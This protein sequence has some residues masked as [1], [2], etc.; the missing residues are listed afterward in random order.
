M[1]RFDFQISQIC[2]TFG[3]MNRDSTFHPLCV[4]AGTDDMRLN[5]PFDYEPHTLVL[6]AAERVRERILMLNIEQ[7]REFHSGK[8]LGVL[9]VR[10]GCEVGFLAA[11]SGSVLGV[12]T[13]EWFVPPIYDLNSE[14]GYFRDCEGEISTIN[15]EIERIEN[16][17]EYHKLSEDCK[18]AESTLEEA[19]TQARAQY[20]A[21]KAQ[22]KVL[23]ESGEREA[24]ERAERES[25]HQKG[26]IRRLETHLRGE[27]ERSAAALELT[28]SELS[29]LKKVRTELSN[30]LQR[31]MFESYRLLNGRGE[32]RTVLSIFESQLNRLPPAGTG[33]CA[34]PK[35]LQYAFRHGMTPL[36]IG[37]FWYGESQRGE[38]RHD[39]VFYGACRGKCHPILRFM[40]E[41]VELDEPLKYPTESLEPHTIYED[42]EL[43][44][45]DKPSGLLSV[46]G[47]GDDPSLES[48]IT[49]R[50]PEAR[51]VHRLDQDT[52]GVILVAKSLDTYRDLQRQFAQR[53]LSKRY[54]ALVEG[55]INPPRG[56]ISLPLSLDPLDRP[57]QRVNHEGGAPAY[58]TYEVLGYN[59]RDNTT[60]LAL[61]PHTGRTHQLR[62]HAAHSEG[63]NAPIVGDRLYGRSNKK[64]AQRLMLHAEQI[65]FTHPHTQERVT[66]VAKTT[67]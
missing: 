6:A 66:F 60:R 46:R 32:C 55:R 18:R 42:E 51:V 27:L 19:I 23:R 47:R 59:E 52:S 14:E 56:E 21:A 30:A 28:Q 64:S 33:D 11:F 2:Y 37:E 10:R 62:L 48:F 26:E 58:T 24:C 49:Q 61:Y 44:V 65:S 17:A 1:R 38:V 41:G 5:N 22:R 36:A 39:G 40:L 7:Q 63:L 35:L 3:G 54:I 43:L 29:R 50:Y 12:T 34:A 20:R 9:V 8:M 13:L 4:G 53:T 15:H 31:R 67:I 25:Q 57:R 45:L 16:S